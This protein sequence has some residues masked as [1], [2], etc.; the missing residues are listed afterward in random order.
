MVWKASPDERGTFSR[1][2]PSAILPP[3]KITIAAWAADERAGRLY[4]LDGAA[5]VDVPPRQERP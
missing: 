4:P 5:M 3:G 1:T 2:L